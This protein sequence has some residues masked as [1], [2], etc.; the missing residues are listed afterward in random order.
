M[1]LFGSALFCKNQKCSLGPKTENKPL[2]FFGGGP[3]KGGGGPAL[4]KNSQIIPYFLSEAP[5]ASFALLA[6]M[7]TSSFLWDKQEEEKAEEVKI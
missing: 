5:L 6:A 2:N 3:S 1:G 4:G 7:A